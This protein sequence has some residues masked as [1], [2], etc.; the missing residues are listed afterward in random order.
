V[1]PRPYPTTG[2]EEAFCELRPEGVLGSTPGPGSV[3]VS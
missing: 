1:T 2:V 3:G